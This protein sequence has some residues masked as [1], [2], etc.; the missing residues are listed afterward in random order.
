MLELFFQTCGLLMMSSEEI[1][2]TADR[3]FR[4]AGRDMNALLEN[5]AR[6]MQALDGPRPTVAPGNPSGRG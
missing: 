1:D 4:V 3:A 6:V 5:A 2:H